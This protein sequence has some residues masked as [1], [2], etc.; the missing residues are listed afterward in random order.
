MTT[1]WP[2]RMRHDA[3]YLLVSAVSVFVRQ[4]PMPT[5]RGLGEAVGRL[6]YRVAGSRRRIA[7]D[8]VARAMPELPAVERERIVRGVFEH[9]A[10]MILELIRF[11]R[12]TQEEMLACIEIEGEEHVQRA[13]AA[14]KGLIFFSA[15][16][17]YWEMQGLANPLC[18]RPI[19]VMARPLDNLR[20]HQMLERIRTVTGNAVIHRQGAV[21]KVLRALAAN[22]GV[23]ILIDQHL[24]S[25]DAVL[26]NFFGRPAAT[27]SMVAALAA[28]TGAAVVPAFGGPLPN[29]RYRFVY[30]PPIDPPD[31]DSPESVRAFTQRCSDRIEAHVRSHPD[32]W[33][34]M[35]R[36]WRDAD[37][38]A[39]AGGASV[40][41]LEE[42]PRG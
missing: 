6:A 37:V 36:R 32:L 11:S 10:R 13:Y 30:E 42:E 18:W 16:F 35:H 31:D 41:Q 1:P 40:A 28:R 29:G 27:S 14:G 34:W 25:P 15:H 24:Q 33:L 4:L 38:A 20:L 22:S 23:A 26:V 21:R 7:L 39:G 9:F 5:V 3:E 2:T 12:L 19:S 17:G 8:N